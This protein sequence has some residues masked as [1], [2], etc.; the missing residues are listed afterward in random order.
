M[1]NAGKKKTVTKSILI[2]YITLDEE[3]SLW[4]I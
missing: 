3:Y 1:F 4:N 2:I